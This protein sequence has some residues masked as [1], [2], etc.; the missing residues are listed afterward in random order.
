VTV[1]GADNL[2]ISD[3]FNNCIRKV[4]PSGI[5]TTV[6]G[7]GNPAD[8]LGDGGPASSARLNLPSGVAIDAKGNLLIADFGNNRIRMMTPAGTISTVVGTG[9][10][11][12]TGDGGP[13]TA[14]QLNAPSSPV[15]DNAGHLFFNDY[16]N[17]RVRMVGSNGTIQTVAGGGSPADGIGDGGLATNARLDLPKQIALDGAGN[18]YIADNHGCRIRR[19]GPV[20]IITTVA[21]TGQAGFS[22]DGGPGTQAQLSGPIGLALDQAG[23][24]FF[25]DTGR[26]EPG[27]GIV[28]VGNQRIREVVGVGAPR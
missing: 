25:S 28:T 21:G 8:G 23:N 27:V 3:Y 24:L 26:V 19:V 14:A 9:Q 13:A 4:S 6:A 17:Q 1:D 18:L 16:G 15:V 22:G 11:G 5:I 7:G 10:A 12:F 20:G 2:Y